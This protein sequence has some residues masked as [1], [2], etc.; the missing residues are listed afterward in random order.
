MARRFNRRTTQ[1]HEVSYPGLPTRN[2]H[3][4]IDNYERARSGDKSMQAFFVRQY[5]SQIGTPVDNFI[6]WNRLSFKPIGRAIGPTPEV[7]KPNSSTL[8]A[9][10]EIHGCTCER[11]CAGCDQGYH[12]SCRYGCKYGQPL[13]R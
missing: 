6:D 13:S 5:R 7:K 3:I 2:L 11:D 8:V 10:P 12:R 4:I 9:K 1:L